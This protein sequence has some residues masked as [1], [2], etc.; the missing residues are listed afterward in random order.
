MEDAQCEIS[1][2]RASIKRREAEVHV[3]QVELAYLN[4]LVA[5]KDLQLQKAEKQLVT[6]STSSEA[7]QSVHKRIA[8]EE[9]EFAEAEAEQMIQPLVAVR[10]ASR[11]DPLER[12]SSLDGD[13]AVST[14]SAAEI[15][16]A[17]AAGQRVLASLRRA[18]EAL[19]QSPCSQLRAELGG[20]SVS[21]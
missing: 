17:T 9:I 15:D 7:P 16:T 6:P 5:Q 14:L 12:L 4:T 21:P 8:K 18:R 11:S 10:E 19:E 1:C 20:L 3:A 2:L 13:S